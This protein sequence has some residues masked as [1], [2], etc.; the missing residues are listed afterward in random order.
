MKS[1]GGRYIFLIIFPLHSWHFLIPSPEST[2]TSGKYFSGASWPQGELSIGTSESSWAKID[3]AS[4]SWFPNLTGY[5]CTL[6]PFLY[7]TSFY[8]PVTLLY[9]PLW[10]PV[11][12]TTARHKYLGIFVFFSGL[13]P[14]LL[15]SKFISISFVYFYLCCH[16]S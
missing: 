11:L 16:V 15:V 8:W 14:H 4:C 3:S 13:L 7:L 10:E 2:T 9:F 5:F 1:S 6:F 12:H